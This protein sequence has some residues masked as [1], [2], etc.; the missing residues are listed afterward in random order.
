MKLVLALGI[1]AMV[2]AVPALAQCGG[3]ANSAGCGASQTMSLKLAAVSG[4][5]LDLGML[6]GKHPLVLLVAGT[7]K[8][9]KAAALAVQQAFAHDHGQPAKFIGVI[10]AGMKTTKN[11]ARGWKLG[12]TVL[13]DP[14]KKAM[15]WLK[16]SGVPRVVFVSAAGRVVKAESAIATASVLEGLKALAQTEEKLV[17]PVCGMT[18]TKEGAAGSYSFGGKTYYFCNSACKDSF[19]KSPEKYL[20][21]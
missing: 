13:A 1:A 10:N 4:D 7:D 16:V 9:S 15:S 2:S 19:I 3:C 11:V 18:V 8:L 5:T 21:Q 12:Y 17:D 20:S 6:V 14:D